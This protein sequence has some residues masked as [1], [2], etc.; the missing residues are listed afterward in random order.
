LFSH[1]SKGVPLEASQ[2]I[3]FNQFIAQLQ[4]AD[5]P[6]APNYFYLLS[7][8]EPD[9]TQAL[10]EIWTQIPLW[11]RQSIMEDVE[12]LSANDMLLSFV[13][14]STLALQDENAGI[15]RQAVRS[16]WEYDE[17]KLA[18]VFMRMV[19]S[20]PDVEVRA[21]ATSALG[22]YIYNGEIEELSPILLNQIEELLLQIIRGGDA[23]NVRRAALE[24][25]GFSSREEVPALIKSAYASKDKSWVASAL[26]AMGRSC[27]EAWTQQVLAMLSHPSPQVRVEAVRAAGELEIKKAT[28]SLIELLDD[29]DD[30]TR[31][32]C[33]W[34]LSQ[35]GGEGVRQILEDLIE[36][37]EDEDSLEFLE[38]A[39]D[40]LDFTESIDLMPLFDFDEEDEDD[41]DLVY[42]EDFSEEDEDLD[43]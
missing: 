18:P 25:L 41:E 36:E 13:D 33:I 5:H 30:D 4:D 39:L 10:A 17:D 3:P 42:Y 34:S 7:D 21:A 40:N 35:L 8:L 6:L 29:P 28:R 27:D 23:P 9:E 26:F 14:F 38:T 19:Q 20:D 1:K 11:R 12:V 31:L 32:A 15:R 24:A 22:R 37:T 43:N 16:L 2:R